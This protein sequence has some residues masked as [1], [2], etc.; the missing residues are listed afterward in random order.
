MYTNIYIMAAHKPL[1]GKFHTHRMCSWYLDALLTSQYLEGSLNQ[2][3][4]IV[5]INDVVLCAAIVW[6]VFKE[7]AHQTFFFSVPSPP[8]CRTQTNTLTHTHIHTHTRA[9][10][11]PIFCFWYAYLHTHICTH[12]STHI[13]IYKHTHIHTRMHTPCQMYAHGRGIS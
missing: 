6:E 4:D 3:Y 10:V 12:I 5:S 9:R 2:C 7:R 8:P 1:I 13:Q 11:S